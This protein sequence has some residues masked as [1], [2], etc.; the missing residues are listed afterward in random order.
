MPSQLSSSSTEVAVSIVPVRCSEEEPPLLKQGVTELFK[1]YF[2][3]LF[4]L[5]CDLGFQDFQSEWINLPGKYDFSS[6]GGLFVAITTSTPASLSS[7]DQIVGC[8]ALR[9]FEESCG[10]IKRMFLRQE[11]RR[12]GI[13]KQMA[14]V[15]VEHAWKEG[16]RE[17][18]LDSLERLVCMVLVI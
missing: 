15:V 7:T 8:I 2:D 18:K 3:E 12:Q 10:E 17:I 5:G 6:R 1:L 11:Y 16:Y 4:Q 14:Q 9:P 13:G